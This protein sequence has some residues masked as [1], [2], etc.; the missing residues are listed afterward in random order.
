MSVVN[1]VPSGNRSISG[2][3]SFNG[4]TPNLPLT[5]QI[6]TGAFSGTS[7]GLT[8]SIESSLDYGVSWSNIGTAF[9]SLGPNQV[10]R[11]TYLS[12]DLA[13]FSDLLRVRWTISGTDPNVTFA[14][15]VHAK[16]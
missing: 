8:V 13:P 5:V 1:V 3:Q 12:T 16:P 2:E 15:Y 9:S 11:K 7:P 14:V 4:W 10:Y 6:T